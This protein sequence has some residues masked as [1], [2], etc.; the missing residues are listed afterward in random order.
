M[1]E[2]QSLVATM[3]TEEESEGRV[4]L[5]GEKEQLTMP[6]IAHHDQVSFLSPLLCHFLN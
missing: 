3:A 1:M 2:Q 6:V 5:H 4:A